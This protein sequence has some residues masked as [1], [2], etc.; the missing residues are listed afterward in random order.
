M[1]EGSSSQRRLEE[2]SLCC[3]QFTDCSA[4]L[5]P[6]RSRQRP[7]TRRFYV[8]TFLLSSVQLTSGFMC[9][10]MTVRGSFVGSTWRPNWTQTLPLRQTAELVSMLISEGLAVSSSE[11]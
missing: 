4:V 2:L 11:L 3:N 8:S 7:A 9:V 6:C 5:F 1:A 10:L